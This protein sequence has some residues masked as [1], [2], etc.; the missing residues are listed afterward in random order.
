VIREL[1]QKGQ[2]WLF[3]PKN[4]DDLD[5]G[6]QKIDVQRA[7]RELRKYYVVKAEPE[8]RYTLGIAYPA[9]RVDAHGDFTTPEELELAAWEFMKRVQKG[10][11]TIGLMHRAGLVGVGV[12]VESYIYRGPEW[13]IGDQVVMPGDWLLGVIWEE[14]A[15]ELIKAGEI[16]G[17]SIQGL[18]RKVWKRSAVQIA[19]ESCFSGS[20]R[21]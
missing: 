8:R 9:N 12:V 3:W 5:K 6:L 14:A 11:A 7:A 4:P 13:R 19:A 21:I 17:Y 1:A 20:L 10:Q 16:T 18:A 15:W 2:R